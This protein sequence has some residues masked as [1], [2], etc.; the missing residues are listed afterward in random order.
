MIE[1]WPFFSKARRLCPAPAHLHFNNLRQKSAHHL[2]LLLIVIVFPDNV[3][4]IYKMGT[5][6]M[7]NSSY[8]IYLFLTFPK[9]YILHSQNNIVFAILRNIFKLFLIQ[10]ILKTDNN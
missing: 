1:K 2:L 7:N 4:K 9:T 6:N 3:S 10:F 8:I 5:K